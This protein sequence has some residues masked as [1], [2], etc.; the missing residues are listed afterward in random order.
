MSP[1]VLITAGSRRVA[2]VEAFRRAMRELRL[3]GAVIVTDVNDLSP[4]VHVADRACEVSLSTAPTYLDEIAEICDVEGVDL[5]IPTIDEELPL[6]GDAI[7][8]FSEQGVTVF[9]S[10]RRTAEQCNDKFV[11]SDVL[12]AHGVPAAVSYLPDTLPAE[13]VFPL[14]VKPRLGRGSVAAFAVQNARELAFFLE[15]V[16]DPI[17][18]EYLDGPEYTIDLLCDLGGRP[19]SIV[20]RER[21][22]IRAG[23]SDRGRTVDDPALTDVALACADAFEFRGA[24]NIQCRVRDGR[25]TIFEIN[26][27]YSGGIPLT[28]A[29]GADFPKLMLEMTLGRRVEPALGQFEAGLC[30]TSYEATLFIEPAG[31]RPLRRCEPHS[32]RE[33]V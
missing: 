11:T 1:N 13:P 30:M 15:Y 8:A 7:D 5:L 28:I 3:G 12:R 27:R 10:V 31:R 16:D 25:A 18:Q 14:F 6:F 2:L 22:V 23:V 32:L 24:V 26:P 29:A 20:P 17:V 4:A 19:I 21:L 33:A 9:S